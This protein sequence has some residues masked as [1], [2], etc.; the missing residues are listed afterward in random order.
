M[1]NVTLNSKIQLRNDTA[2]NWVTANPVLLKGEIG[3]EIDTLKF[4][5]GDGTTSWSSLE[6]ASGSSVK[7]STTNP[8]ATDTDY[9]I[10]TL[11]INTASGAIY[12]LE[13]NADGAWKKLVTSGDILTEA[14]SAQKLKTARTIGLTGDATGS[15]SFDGSANKTITVVLKNS[16]VT[17][18]TYT[19]LTVNAKGIVT[20][21]TQITSA[22]VPTL[23]TSKISGLG[24]AAT[25]NV[26]TA[27]GNVVEIN[28]S[29]KIDES[30]L[31]AIAI[32]EV[33]EVSSQT[34]M[35]ALSAQTGDI[36]IRS[37]ENKS[38]I[39]SQSPA[40][41]LANWKLL[42]TPTD[43]VLSVNSKTGAVV[44]TT[45]DIAEGSKMYYTEARATSNFNTNF[46]GKSSTG[47]T[48]GASIL[49]STDVLILNGGSSSN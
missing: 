22:D 42:R 30:L 10:G 46:A 16:G 41:T 2:S 9:D 38:Y 5:F 28:S 1:A 4:K 33:Y 39:L 3:V 21:A 18:G 36:A 49:H 40:A 32:T 6:Y 45:T 19:K 47:L 13:D 24:T 26:G 17:A 25:K 48:D 12:I 31:P 44:L 15:T 20:S 8:T 27:S 43:T 7:I 37:D 35:L 23:P 14:V 11:W 29:G 34:A